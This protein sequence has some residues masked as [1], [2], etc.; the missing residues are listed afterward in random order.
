MNKEK[1]IKNKVLEVFLSG[2]KNPSKDRPWEESRKD[3]TFEEVQEIESL[4]V[5]TSTKDLKIRGRKKGI[6]TP[7]QTFRVD[8]SL[9]RQFK[10]ATRKKEGKSASEILRRFIYNY[11]HRGS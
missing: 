5:P 3:L 4:R 6:K 11:V 9:W 10:S 7:R 1:K 8:E 2:K